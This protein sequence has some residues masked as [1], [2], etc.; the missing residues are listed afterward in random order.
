MGGRLFSHSA[1]LGSCIFPYML[2]T[3]FFLVILRSSTSVT[4]FAN[5][6]VNSMGGSMSVSRFSSWLKYDRGS[7]SS[8]TLE[9][10]DTNRLNSQGFS[11]SQSQKRPSK[12]KSE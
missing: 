3:T 10:E 9:L 1:T 8:C 4:Q 12:M 6:A 5:R 7:R 2:K 11:E